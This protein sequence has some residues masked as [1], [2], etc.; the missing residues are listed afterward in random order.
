[1]AT[2]QRTHDTEILQKNLATFTRVATGLRNQ[3]VR[4]NGK[5]EAVQQE[6]DLLRKSLGFGGAVWTI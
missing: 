6:I 4:D 3:P 1:M 5:V 2:Q